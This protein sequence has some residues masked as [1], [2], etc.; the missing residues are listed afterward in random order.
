MYLGDNELVALASR[1]LNCL[2]PGGHLFF[3]ESCFR[4][5]GDRSRT[6]NPSHYRTMSAYSV[7][8]EEARVGSGPSGKRFQLARPAAHCL[9]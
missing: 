8:F 9:P 5:S 3:R 2:K 6:F 4:Q 7:V 1:L